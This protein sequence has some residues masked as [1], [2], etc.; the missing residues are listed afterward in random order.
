[1]KLKAQKREEAE[2]R[3][4]SYQALTTEQ[5]LAKLD[6]GKFTASKQRLKL[7]TPAWPSPAE[8]KS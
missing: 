5:K 6:A 8:K 1:M 3:K 4:A 7:Q 2:L